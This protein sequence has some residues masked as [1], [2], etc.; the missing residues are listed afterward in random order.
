MVAFSEETSAVI[1]N[2]KNKIRDNTPEN[3]HP[4]GTIIRVKR[5]GQDDVTR[6]Y[7]F[8]YAHGSWWSTAVSRV[9]VHSR[10][11]NQGFMDFLSE[12]RTTKVEVAT[13]FETIKQRR[14]PK[15]DQ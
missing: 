2:I 7:A 10:Y 6:T 5:R 9:H 14:K 11:S 12:S 4:E 15:H 8:V 3:E 1:T 13:A